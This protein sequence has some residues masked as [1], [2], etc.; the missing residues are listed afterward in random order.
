MTPSQ[1]WKLICDGTHTWGFSAWPCPC[2]LLNELPRVNS[3]QIM[4]GR[5]P[6]EACGRGNTLSSS[7][8]RHQ[9]RAPFSPLPG[10]CSRWGFRTYISV[11]R[12]FWFLPEKGGLPARSGGV[13]VWPPPAGLGAT[14]HVCRFIRYPVQTAA[15]DNL[16]P[17]LERYYM[18]IWKEQKQGEVWFVRFSW[19]A[20]PLVPGKPEA[21]MSPALSGRG[22]SGS[23]PCP[24]PSPHHPS[25]SSGPWKEAKPSQNRVRASFCAEGCL[26]PAGQSVAQ[27]KMFQKDLEACAEQGRSCN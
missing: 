14:R 1:K 18:Q 16:I 22:N 20:Y 21:R 15:T 5:A 3:H 11:A 13:V 26:S 9:P 4:E 6:T 8:M 24:P 10:L 25:W 19:C 7:V 12:A 23:C 27:S 2:L 17:A